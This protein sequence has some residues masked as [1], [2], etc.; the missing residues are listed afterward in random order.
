MTKKIFESLEQLINVIVL[1]VSG[2]YITHF[3]LNSYT[4]IPIKLSMNQLSQILFVLYI[5]DVFKIIKAFIKKDITV[6]VMF[7]VTF[8]VTFLSYQASGGKYQFLLFI[9]AIIFSL[10]DIEYDKVLSLYLFL[11]G[12]ILIVAIF[13]SQVNIISNYVYSGTNKVRSSWGICYPTDYATIILFFVM[14][15][16]TKRK[17]CS[18]WLMLCPAILSLLNAIYIAS[19]RTSMICSTV[20]II[21]IVIY[22]IFHYLKEHFDL[23]PLKKVVNV[24]FMCV[25]PICAIYTFVVCLLFQMDVPFAQTINN[26]M[27]NRLGLI[28]NGVQNYGIHPF[29]SYFE[30]KGG[31]FGG[32]DFYNGY[33]FIDNS[34]ALLFIRYGWVYFGLILTLWLFTMKKALKENNYKVAIVMSIIAFHSISEHHY[35]D[36]SFN[37][38]L[39]MP[40]VNFENA[41]EEKEYNKIIEN[42]S[43]LITAIVFI[44]LLISV[45]PSFLSYARTFVT[46]NNIQNANSRTMYILFP[47]L[48]LFASLLFGVIYACKKVIVFIISGKKVKMIYSVI[49]VV[50]VLICFIIPQYKNSIFSSAYDSYLEIFQNEEDIVKL[51]QKNKEGKL[52]STDVP[53]YYERYFKGFSSGLLQGEELAR[54]KNITVITSLDLDSEVFISNGFEWM[55]I[56]DSHAIYTNDNKV[57]KALEK[58][59]YQLETYYAKEHQMDIAYWGYLNGIPTD[60]FGQLNVRGGE[61]GLYVGPYCY[62]HN[63][64]YDFTLNLFGLGS[65]SG[66][67]LDY[68]QP[69]AN[70]SVKYTDTDDV[71]YNAQIYPS[72]D[73]NGNYSYEF[74]VGSWRTANVYLTLEPINDCSIWISSVTYKKNQNN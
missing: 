18:D 60:E 41:K 30:L 65:V 31:G 53:E 43:V 56:S 25:F 55:Q 67:P 20:F 23:T 71:L 66:N 28:I 27:S 26:W 39:F 24:L 50:A 46:I 36:A 16:W 68:S 69:I 52:Y 17:K 38:L 74:Q 35:I 29:G 10:Y 14:F 4:A 61:N 21:G 51:I 40:F 64:T 33:N 32:T 19:S 57:I 2:A 58:K 48:M 63:R 72:F 3:M 13:A 12:L 42:I 9:P 1:I 34:Y 49:L 62:L 59:N 73:E 6:L 5:V 54:Q 15:L 11:I 47:V 22:N 44:V 70:F 45:F 7:A 37:L 8:L